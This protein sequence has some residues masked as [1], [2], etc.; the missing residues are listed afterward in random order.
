[1][2]LF[3][4]ENGTWYV[5]MYRGHKRSLKT[6]DEG[7]ARKAFESLEREYLRGRLTR[8]EKTELKLFDDFKKEYLAH[9]EDKAPNTQRADRL[10][11]DKFREHFGNRSMAGITP[12]IL[13][14]FKSWLHT[15]GGEIRDKETGK[16]VSRCPLKAS[17]C[18]AH[19]RHLK[20]ALKTARRWGYINKERNENILEDFKQ[21]HEDYRKPVFMTREDIKK[22]LSFASQDPIMKVPIAIQVYL[23]ISRAEII[24]PIVI[25]KDHISYRR[26]KTGK[27][28]RNA[29]PDGLKPYISHL[30]LGIQKVFP[31]KNPRTYSRYFERIVKK[32][33]L[34]G[35]SPH[36][37]RHSL[38]TNL[39]L[40]GED[41]KTVSEILGHSDIYVVARNYAHITDEKKRA[42]LNKLKY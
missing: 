28:I 37:V 42:A 8:L 38:A 17:S 27:L 33:E 13:D 24:A 19:I 18:N 39:L 11:L 16:V 41:L 35:I 30:K 31:W 25:E 26:I 7:K 14:Q 4:R 2:K 21:Y 6:K 29:I 36:K 34:V 40:A 22:L 23:G 32:C 1:M 3:Q 10:A 12:K 5:Q 15:Q 20:I 9:R